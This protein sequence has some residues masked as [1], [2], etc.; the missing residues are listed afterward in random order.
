I[1]NIKE[2][3]LDV[4]GMVKNLKQRYLVDDKR[5]SLKELYRLAAPIQ[6]RT[7]I[8]RSI[9]TTQANGV[10]VKMVF[11]QIRNKKSE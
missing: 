11:V 5:V 2:Q 6:G 10:P 4:I 8:L 7:G 1:K 3:G 9:H